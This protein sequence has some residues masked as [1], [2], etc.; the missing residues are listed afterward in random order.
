MLASPPKLPEKYDQCFF[1]CEWARNWIIAV[2]LDDAGKAVRMER[3]AA[4][5]E[6]KRPIELELGPD[7]ALYCIEFGTAW[8]NNKDSQVIR[9][10]TA[11]EGE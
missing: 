3:F 2:K 4:K 9:I 5:I 7:G 6:L 8:E 10:E 1:V 11:P